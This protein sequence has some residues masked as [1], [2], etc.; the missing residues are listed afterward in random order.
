MTA[1]RDTQSL[2][3]VLTHFNMPPGED[4]PI[5]AL[6]AR[7]R[8]Q[9]LVHSYLYYRLDTNIIDDATFDR[10]ARELVRLQNEFPEEAA[11]TVF[12]DVFRDFEGSTGFHLPLGDPSIAATAELLLR[13][14]EKKGHK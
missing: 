14:V 11:A 1:K 10:W 5:H 8:R 6:I 9:V 7:R 12:A 4:K 3:A 13:I 2:R